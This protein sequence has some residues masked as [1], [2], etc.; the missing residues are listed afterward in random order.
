VEVADRVAFEGLLAGLVTGDLRQATDPMAFK[1][2]MEGRP[3]QARN[4]R[5]QSIEAVIQRQ[6]RVLTE[7]NDD[8]LFLG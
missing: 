4:S 7:G 2:S 8:R 5:L 1:T 3:G 6:Q